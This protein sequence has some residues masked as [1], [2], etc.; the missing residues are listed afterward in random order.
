MTAERQDSLFGESQPAE[1]ARRSPP[2]VERA[3]FPVN[4][5]EPRTSS[6]YDDLG[7]RVPED[8]PDDEPAQVSDVAV[9]EAPVPEPETEGRASRQK[10]VAYALIRISEDQSFWNKLQ[11]DVQEGRLPQDKIMDEWTREMNMRWEK[12][13]KLDPVRFGVV[14]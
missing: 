7:G 13:K 14:K 4:R 9:A 8:A 3:P 6:A 2:S 11:L 5:Y 12:R 1:V 10:A